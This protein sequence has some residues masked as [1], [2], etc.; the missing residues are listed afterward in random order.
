MGLSTS[1][2][3]SSGGSLETKPI[4]VIGSQTGLIDDLPTELTPPL[5]VSRDSG[6]AKITF[7][8]NGGKLTVSLSSTLSQGETATTVAQVLQA[9]GIGRLIPVTLTRS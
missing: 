8:T 2:N 4:V 6:S 7:G 5:T 1:I 3:T 9:N